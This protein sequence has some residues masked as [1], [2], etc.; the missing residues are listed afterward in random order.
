MRDLL[1]SIII[2]YLIICFALGCKKQLKCTYYV[3]LV[4]AVTYIILS[5]CTG[6][7]ECYKPKK[8]KI[9]SARARGTDLTQLQDEESG[10]FRLVVSLSTLPSRL[11]GIKPVIESIL[12]GTVCPD[13]IYLNLP[14]YSKREGIEYKITDELL[15][16]SPKLKINNTKDDYG[17]VT[18][19]YPTLEQETDPETII[20]CIDD[21]IEYDPRLIETLL[22]SSQQYP[23]KCICLSGWNYI[24]LGNIM[25]FPLYFPYFFVRKVDILQCYGGVLYKRKFFDNLSLFKKYM[26]LTPCF[27]TDDITISKY[28]K[29]RGIEIFMIPSSIKN[30]N[31]HRQKTSALSDFNTS[32]NQWIKCIKAEIDRS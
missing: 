31:L 1:I 26:E 15:N 14:E 32:N 11:G 24:N 30:K 29:E 18:K 10:E 25:T 20:I 5:I 17:P 23:D 19:L 4:M 3:F 27:T 21:D 22:Q 2:I 6:Y 16:I 13:V 7:V 28:L 9:P 8:Y 12:N